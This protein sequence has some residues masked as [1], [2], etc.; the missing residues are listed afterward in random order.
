MIDVPRTI[1]QDDIDAYKQRANIV[2]SIS[3]TNPIIRMQNA[4]FAGY[5]CLAIDKG[6]IRAEKKIEF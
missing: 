1:T 3:D 6:H 4:L 2:G 5:M